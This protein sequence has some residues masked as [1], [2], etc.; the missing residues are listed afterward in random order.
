M[1]AAGCLWYMQGAMARVKIASIDDVPAGQGRTVEAA[2]KT[3]ALFNVDG[4]YYAIDN[5]CS[6]RGG[7]LGEGDRKTAWSPVRGTPGS[8]T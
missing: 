2:G 8:G 3:L 6:H 7:P 5:T 4:A 1:D